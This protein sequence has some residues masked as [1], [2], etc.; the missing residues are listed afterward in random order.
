VNRQ[1]TEWMEEHGIWFRI[2]PGAPERPNLFLSVA[3]D[4]AD[5]EEPWTWA[6]VEADPDEDIEYKIGLAGATTLEAG[7]AAAEGRADQYRHGATIN[8]H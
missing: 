3:P 5:A 1:P 8:G 7:K 4:P 6:V 2:V